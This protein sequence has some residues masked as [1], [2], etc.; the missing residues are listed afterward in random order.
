MPLFKSKCR[1]HPHVTEADALNEAIRLKRKY[2]LRSWPSRF[3]CD[4]C[5][6]YH[7]KGPSVVSGKNQYHSDRRWEMLLSKLRIVDRA[8]PR[9]VGADED[10]E[11][12][13]ADEGDGGDTDNE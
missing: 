11:Y 7:V 8:G 1:K 6:A 12:A 5:R 2:H 4:H 9:A 13:A 10:Q 3:Y